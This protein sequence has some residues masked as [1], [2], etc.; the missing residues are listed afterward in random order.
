MKMVVFMLRKHLIDKFKHPS[1]WAN[2]ELVNIVTECPH[3]RENTWHGSTEEN[4]MK[5]QNSWYS[6]TGTLETELIRTNQILH[7][8][9]RSKFAYTDGQS[10]STRWKEAL[11]AQMTYCEIRDAQSTVLTKTDKNIKWHIHELWHTYRHTLQSLSFWFI[12]M[13][14]SETN[15]W[16]W[17]GDG[18]L[19][20]ILCIWLEIATE[21][22]TSKLW[23]Y[24]LDQLFSTW[25]QLQSEIQ[26]VA[27]MTFLINQT[28]S[29]LLL[30]RS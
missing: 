22:P 26:N 7:S 11:H 20:D 12:F 9:D 5:R 16:L 30:H 28:Q 25:R 23:S 29:L 27:I 10:P 21:L 2:W 3:A 15:P 8:C 6:N 1:E 4:N 17:K 24:Q 18:F 19:T 13:K 14:R